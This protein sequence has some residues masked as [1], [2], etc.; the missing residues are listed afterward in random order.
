[1]VTADDARE[2]V[3]LLATLRVGSY[4]DDVDLRP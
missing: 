4:F 3:R 1:M 2:I